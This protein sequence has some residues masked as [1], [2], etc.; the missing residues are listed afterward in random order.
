MVAESHP[1]VKPP[2]LRTMPP[3]L[4]QAGRRVLVLAVG[5]LRRAA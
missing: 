4:P 5:R 3:R 1:A 2:E